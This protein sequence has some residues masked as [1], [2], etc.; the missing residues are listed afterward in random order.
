VTGSNRISFINCSGNL[1]V[2]EAGVNGSL[3]EG[4]EVSLTL[5][6]ERIKPLAMLPVSITATGT[7]VAGTQYQLLT[8]TV[9][10]CCRRLFKSS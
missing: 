7:A 4:K 3:P 10:F 2:S 9:K 8:P 1:V 6:V 5:N